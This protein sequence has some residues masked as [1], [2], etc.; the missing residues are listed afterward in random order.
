MQSISA[1]IKD[2][3]EFIKFLVGELQRIGNEI[4]NSRIP[5]VDDGMEG[6]MIDASDGVGPTH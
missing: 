5:T 2:R 4:R 3:H 6:T 1:S